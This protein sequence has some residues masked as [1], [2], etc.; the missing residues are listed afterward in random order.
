MPRSYLVFVALVLGLGCPRFCRAQVP[1]FGGAGAFSPEI[2]VVNSG[3]LNDVQATVSADRKYVTL[4]M[5]P[6]SSQLLALHEFAISLPTPVGF[7]GGV[8]FDI[9]GG[10]GDKGDFGT[11]NP[12][13][14]LGP[15]GRGAA[16]FHQRGMTRIV[17]R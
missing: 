5:R 8:S 12:P 6:Q 14:A 2:S 11:I 13:I 16:L 17:S 4:T 1:F 9:V 15:P 3:V 10:A 7:V